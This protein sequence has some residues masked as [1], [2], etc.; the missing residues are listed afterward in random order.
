[1]SVDSAPVMDFPV[2][3]AVDVGKTAV[4]LSVTDA[5][6]HR[7]LGPV[8]FEMIVRGLQG[9]LSLIRGRLAGA[10]APL[11]VGIEAAGHYH[12]PLLMPS[13]RPR[14]VAGAGGESGACGRAAEGAG[15]PAGQD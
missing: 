3:V 13:V 2:V 9:V 12:R 10:N 6:R 15:T 4:A 11:K 1:M 7:L 5:G 8:G 14:W